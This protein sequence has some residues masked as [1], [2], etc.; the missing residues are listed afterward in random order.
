MAAPL[1]K[2]SKSSARKEPEQPQASLPVG[3][4]GMK[5]FTFRPGGAVVPAR[6]TG[7]LCA[8]RRKAETGKRTSIDLGLQPDVEC[9]VLRQLSTVLP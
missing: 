3:V 1:G 6:L 7:S 9:R 5:A 2:V 8:R 4:R